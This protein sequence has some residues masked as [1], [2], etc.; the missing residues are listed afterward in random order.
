[1]F[2]AAAERHPRDEASFRARA[3]RAL[4]DAAGRF[5]VALDTRLELTLAT[6]I[7]DAVF[8]RLIIE[9]EPPGGLAAHRGHRGNR[10]AVQ[11]LQ[12]YVDGLAARERRQLERLAG[13][14]CDGR[15][16][17]FARYRAGRWIVDEPV[18]VDERSVQL[19]LESLISAQT[20]RALT[21]DNL[22][23]D[24]GPE[25]NLTRQLS[26]DLLDQL[27]AELGQNPDGLTAQLYRQW[28]T[29]FAVATGV[30]GMRKR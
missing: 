19:L 2:A 8:N 15:F 24:F 4:E 29:F 23:R 26:R 1:V 28:E 16:M 12:D 27:N 11:Q 9:W 5:G 21:A 13:V 6:G 22:L 20:G 25:T 7:A 3:E 30:V 17:I 10:H 14:A 18:P